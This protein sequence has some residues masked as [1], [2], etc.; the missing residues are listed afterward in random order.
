MTA[1][2]KKARRPARGAALGMAI[3]A[4]V[5]MPESIY[6]QRPARRRLSRSPTSSSAVSEDHMTA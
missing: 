3:A 6:G 4:R 1:T 5:I 2:A